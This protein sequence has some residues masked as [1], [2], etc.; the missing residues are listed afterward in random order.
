MQHILGHFVL[1]IFIVFSIFEF[2]NHVVATWA[3][4]SYCFPVIKGDPEVIN[5]TD[6]H[7]EFT[8][9]R[10][11]RSNYVFLA[12]VTCCYNVVFWIHCD[13]TPFEYLSHVQRFKILKI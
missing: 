13:D 8:K 6:D 5:A 2:S 3:K 11:C 7:L 12:I 1:V 9:A 4:M 10:F